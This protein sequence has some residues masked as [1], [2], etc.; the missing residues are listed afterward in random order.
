VAVLAFY[1]SRHSVVMGSSFCPQFAV[2]KAALFLSSSKD[3]AARTLEHAKEDHDWLGR[4]AERRP[5]F[6][7]F[8][9][10]NRTVS[11]E[12]LIGPLSCDEM[13]AVARP[14]PVMCRPSTLTGSDPVG[15]LGSRLWCVARR[16]RTHQFPA[17][18][19]QRQRPQRLAFTG[20]PVHRPF[21]ER[22][23]KAA[24]GSVIKP[25]PYLAVCQGDV[26]EIGLR[27]LQRMDERFPQVPMEPLD[28]ALDL[29]AIRCAEFDPQTIMFDE[30]EP[31]GL[32]PV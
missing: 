7:H 8:P 5:A 13:C 31:C 23:M 17:A 6:S 1:V 21:L 18:I 28:F 15:A 24:V 20:E 3:G 19:R 9:E 25:W 16:L 4:G 2:Y 27:R 22:G 30:I 14:E 11:Y 12:A 26:N 32:I 29:R 10:A